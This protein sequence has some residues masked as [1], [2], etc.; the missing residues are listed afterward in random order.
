[1]GVPVSRAFVIK[2]TGP[3]ELRITNYTNL[4]SGTCY[5]QIETPVESVFE[6]EQTIF[7]IRLHCN[8]PG[9]YTGTITIQNN[10]TNENPYTFY[11]QGTV[12]P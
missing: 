10:D 12:T 7:R 4:V 1:V 9:T 5:S 6:G 8:T 3:A 11:L 2:N